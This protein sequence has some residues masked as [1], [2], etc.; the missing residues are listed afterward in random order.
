MSPS[1][2][3]L[4]EV[5]ELHRFQ[6]A[7]YGGEPGIRDKGLLQSALAVPQAGFGDRYLHQDLPEMGAAYLFHIV[8][9]H[10]FFDGNKRTGTATALTFLKMNGIQ[11][12]ADPDA[13]AELTLS[14]AKGH[15][16]KADVAVF[17]RKRHR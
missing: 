17:F 8:Q 3:D 6:I 1:F 16:K 2:L 9:N 14:V 13:L 12:T 11:V 10:P 7:R 4:E 15:L 5:L